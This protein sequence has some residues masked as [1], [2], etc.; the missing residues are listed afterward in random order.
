MRIREI[1]VGILLMGQLSCSN[2]DIDINSF[3]DDPSITTLNGTWKVVSFEDFTTNTFECKSQEN[4]WGRDIIVTF[5]DNLNPKFFSGR[6]TTNSVEGEFDY[7]ASRLFKLNRY[8]TTYVNQ[9]MWADKFGAAMTDEEVSFKI[10]RERLR[11]HYDN[12]T[13]SV[14]LTKE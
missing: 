3:N 10:N 1:I 7:V 4:S 9:P 13:K 14:T 5:N 11:V 8:L 2:D 12:K 6:V